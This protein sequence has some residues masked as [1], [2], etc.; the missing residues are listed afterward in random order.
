MITNPHNLS[1]TF[2]FSSSDD[3]F[4]DPTYTPTLSITKKK[5]LGNKEVIKQVTYY[6][7]PETTNLNT[8][9]DKMRSFRSISD[10]LQ[11]FNVKKIY[12]LPDSEW[13]DATELS[14]EELENVQLLLERTKVGLPTVYNE[15]SHQKFF[16]ALLFQIFLPK[17]KY[18][19]VSPERALKDE[20]SRIH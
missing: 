5:K 8:N 14:N 17:Y 13:K 2:S 4:V 10:A 7:P 1:F 6:S 20:E 11:L 19:K 12:L 15:A 9:E 16:D 18:L 3:F